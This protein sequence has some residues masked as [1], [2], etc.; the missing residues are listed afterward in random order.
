MATSRINDCRDDAGRN[1]SYYSLS[2]HALGREIHRFRFFATNVSLTDANATR[3][4]F[5]RALPMVPRVLRTGPPRHSDGSD[6]P[7]LAVKVAAIAASY[8]ERISSDAGR[9]TIS[10]NFGKIL[11]PRLDEQIGRKNGP[12]RGDPVQ[13]FAK[14]DHPVSR[15]SSGE[16]IRGPGALQAAMHANNHERGSGTIADRG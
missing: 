5:T 13:G 10:E 6:G 4:R 12:E 9:G 14:L 3:D 1:P 15:E 16:K 8:P 2:Y 11:S 7:A